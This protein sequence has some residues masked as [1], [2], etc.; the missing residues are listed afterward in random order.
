[1]ATAGDYVDIVKLGWGTSYVTQNLREKLALYRSLGI[2][3]ICGGTLLEIAEVRGKL[4]GYRSWLSENGFESVEVSD[5]TIDLPRERKLEIIETLAQDFRV[6]SEV[7][8]KDAEAIFAPYQWVEW[9]REEL[10]AGSWKVITEA[11]ESGTA[12]IFRGSGEVRSG[13]IDE[14]V[15]ELP[16]RAPA[17]RGAAEVAAGLVH[18]AVRPRGQ[19]RQHPARRGHPARNATARAA[20]RHDERIAAQRL[21]LDLHCHSSASD[22]RSRRRRCVEHAHALGIGTLAL[23]DHDTLGGPGARPPRRPSAW[24]CASCPAPRSRC[25]RPRARCTCSPTCPRPGPSRSRRA[26]GAIADYRASRNQ[27]IVARL[28][29]LGYAIEWEDVARRAQG[30]V[31]RPHIAAALVDAGHVGSLQEAFDRLLADGQPAYVDAGSLGPE[32]AVEVVAA[33]GGAPV[34][35]HP[36]TLRMG[37]AELE[38]FVAGLVGARAARRSSASAPTTTTRSAHSRCGCARSS[39]SCRPAAPTG[40]A[41]PT[42]RELGDVG[43]GAAARRTRSSDSVSHEHAFLLR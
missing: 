26:S 40:T 36:Y 33:S 18:P 25:G 32:E 20:V 10:G 39:A 2:P 34:L 24:A 29:E 35:A 23:T 1:M 22:G 43:P 12:G 28:N 16:R 21:S 30:R 13:L 31:G 9:I 27:R 6:L 41:A 4:D 42:S 38:R 7:G 17:L 5:G 11:R 37:D 8:S 15:H 19:P 3:V 14:I